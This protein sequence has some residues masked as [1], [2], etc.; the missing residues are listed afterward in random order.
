[1][2]AW[3]SSLQG[4]GKLDAY[5]LRYNNSRQQVQGLPC[6]RGKR[7]HP[8][9]LVAGFC[10][11]ADPPTVGVHASLC[12]V[13]GNVGVGGLLC[14]KV[15]AAILLRLSSTCVQ[16][17]SKISSQQR[18]VT[19]PARHPA[20]AT[21]WPCLRVRSVSSLT[22]SCCLFGCSGVCLCTN[23]AF[24]LYSPYVSLCFTLFN[25]PVQDTGDQ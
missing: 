18:E 14:R 16:K 22:M 25:T 24:R 5:E 4:Y 13:T 12:I 9:A 6:V 20:G 17:P 21:F 8:Y 7:G 10:H 2:L 15:R 23:C 11:Q 19:E 1:M 3:E